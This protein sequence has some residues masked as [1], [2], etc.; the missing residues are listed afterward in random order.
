MEWHAITLHECEYGVEF[1][2]N[3][4]PKCSVGGVAFFV[5]FASHPSPSLLIYQYIIEIKTQTKESDF[6]KMN[7]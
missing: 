3:E 7:F 6:L 5:C 1:L 4:L 2:T